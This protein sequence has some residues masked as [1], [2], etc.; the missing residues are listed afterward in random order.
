MQTVTLNFDVASGHQAGRN[1]DWIKTLTVTNNT[2]P[3]TP[4]DLT[5]MTVTMTVRPYAGAAAL[6]TISSPSSGVSIPT[7]TNGQ[8]TLTI[9][10]AAWSA[11]PAPANP[12]DVYTCLYDILVVDGS[13]HTFCWLEGKI[14]VEYGVG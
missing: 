1:R 4:F 12:G 3:A 2:V 13:G 7:P 5:G 6:A 10:K 11:T 14:D 8:M 9:A